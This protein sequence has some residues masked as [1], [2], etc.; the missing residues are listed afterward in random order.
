M[1]KIVEQ[2]MGNETYYKCLDIQDSTILSEKNVFCKT[3]IIKKGN[4]EYFMFYDSEMRPISDAFAYVN[5]T[6]AEKSYNTRIKAGEA[7][8]VLLCFEEMIDKKLQAFT[9]S[10]VDAFKYFLHGYSPSG[11]TMALEL[12][13]IRSNDTVNGYLSIYR[14]YLEFLGV[15][16]HSLFITT[17]RVR[18]FDDVFDHN[19]EA[20]SAHYKKND[21]SPKKVIE[22]PR[23][24]SVEEFSTILQHVR[25]NYTVREEII[26]R[27]MFQCGLRIGEVLGL[28]ADDLV[29]E[30]QP[31]GTYSAIAYLRN[32]VSDNKDQRAKTC[33]KV[34]STKQYQTDDYQTSGYGYQTV[35][36]PGDLYDLINEYI[37]DM[38]SAAR[39]GERSQVRYYNKTIADR[40]R[41]SSE[42]EDDNY[43]IF[44]NSVGTRLS[45]VSWNTIL[46]EIFE[47]VGIS[48]DKDKRKNNLNHRFRHGYAMFNVKYLGVK[49]IELAR[50]LRHSSI[51][52][53]LCYYQPTISD[54]IKLKT[55]F[56]ESLYDIVPSLRRDNIC[57]IL[58]II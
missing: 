16:E 10:D 39:D 56:A 45:A 29:N 26:I 28:T 31:N 47:A 37:E 44:I 43:Y 41:P 40:V 14:G 21:R 53:V 19:N 54:Q 3:A 48:V 34:F 18:F 49:E 17:G 50:L 27:L 35:V 33:M 12:K 20:A 30:K 57:P 46:R 13:T 9:S 52:S 7:L 2:K 42:Y 1:K 55:D 11:Q 36:V 4:M 15:T 58:N 38:H 8:K 6:L 25:Q 22:V 51:T 23:Y 32:R 24:I 5:Q